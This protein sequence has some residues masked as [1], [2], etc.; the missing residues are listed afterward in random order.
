[1]V[2]NG[3]DFTG[4]FGYPAYVHMYSAMVYCL[5]RKHDEALSIL[6]GVVASDIESLS[7]TPLK[8]YLYVLIGHLYA[9]RGEY[10][11]AIDSYIKSD[12]E[13]VSNFI[14]QWAVMH[15]EKV[16]NGTVKEEQTYV[17]GIERIARDIMRKGSW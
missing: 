5:L 11:E 9:R 6:S 12:M 14:W 17:G 16:M 4:S 1:M 10:K 7:E 15:A 3:F 2:I 13:K 8:S